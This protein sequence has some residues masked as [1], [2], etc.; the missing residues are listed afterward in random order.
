MSCFESLC[1]LNVRGNIMLLS[2]NLIEG[3]KYYIMKSF[4]L[5]TLRFT[6]VLLKWLDK[7]LAF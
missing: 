3:E 4:E 6:R 2:R 7:M 5:L 1:T